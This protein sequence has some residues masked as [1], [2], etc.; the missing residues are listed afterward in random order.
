ML[1]KYNCTST[2]RIVNILTAL[3]WWKTSNKNLIYE[4][5][6]FELV[7]V[8]NKKRNILLFVS[9]DAKTSTSRI[10]PRLRVT[11]TL[12]HLAL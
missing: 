10:I 8:V 2:S 3:E 11:Q 7:I 12:L 6:D 5:I 9:L 1:T 4:K